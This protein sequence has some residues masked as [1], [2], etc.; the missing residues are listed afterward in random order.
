MVALGNSSVGAWDN[1]SV[2]A[3]GNSSV[4]AWDNS[5]VEAR[6][7]SSVLAPG[8][9]S[10]VAL[11][12]SSVEAWNNS[13]V[14]ARNNSSVLALGNSSVEARDHSSVEA[15]NNSSVE[16]RGNSS[17][18]AWDNSSVVALDN[19]SV[20]ALGNSSVV[21]RGNSQI[22]DRTTDHKIAISGNARIVYDPRTPQEYA[23]YT[24]AE[25][26]DGKIRLYKAVHKRDGRF[27]SEH[28]PRFTYTI[29]E[30]VVADSLTT[31]TLEDCGH[32]IHA[33]HVGWCLDFG[34]SWD[35][36][37]ILEVE[38]DMDG[39]VVPVMGCG[40]VRAAKCKVIREVP[41]EE[42]GLYGKILAKRWSGNE[43]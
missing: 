33:A 5:S 19:S 21:A 42:C 13:S 37:A 18:E 29:G 6:D 2:V 9:S 10:V 43:Q 22:T 4:E 26:Q 16:A 15:R 1:S 31:D 27:I 20:L 3:R 7:H 41:L 34:D 23:S 38:M 17:V 25:V 24:G 36:L 11:G 8:N 28:D 35:D 32:G 12:N 39:L 14:L 30:E 40:K